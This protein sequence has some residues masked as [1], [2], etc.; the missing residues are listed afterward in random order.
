MNVECSVAIMNR[1][2]LLLLTILSCTV[3]VF[4]GLNNFKECDQIK[5]VVQTTTPEIVFFVDKIK[6][7]TAAINNR[8]KELERDLKGF[9]FPDGKFLSDYVP[10]LGGTPLRVIVMTGFRS[11]STFIGE[12]IS[13][14][15]GNFFYYEPIIRF[16]N[17]K[18]IRSPPTSIEAIEDIKNLLNCNYYNLDKYIAQGKYFNNPLWYN[19]PLWSYCQKFEEYCFNSTFLTR[20]CGL[21]PFQTLKI[22]RM[23]L[24]LIEEFL[25]NEKYN[26]FYEDSRSLF[27]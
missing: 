25:A 9:K 17:E 15:P 11:G 27:D 2:Y 8:R 1:R 5:H 21:Y 10:E 26:K 23:S 18:K 24:E 14:L 19:K 3:I 7:I 20:F 16:G 13:S 12:L 6:T 4:V 22:V